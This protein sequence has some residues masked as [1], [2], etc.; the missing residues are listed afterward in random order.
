VEVF[1]P[2]STRVLSTTRS[3]SCLFFRCSKLN[4]VGYLFLM[5]TMKAVLT[6]SS[7]LTSSFLDSNIWRTYKLWISLYANLSFY[8]ILHLRFN[9]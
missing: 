4:A 9:W 5:F 3:P 1:D 2:A 7:S 6:V 8:H